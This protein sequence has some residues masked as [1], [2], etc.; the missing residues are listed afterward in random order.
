MLLFYGDNYSWAREK[1][2]GDHVY[3]SPG[4]DAVYCTMSQYGPGEVI[5]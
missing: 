1:T 4:Q 3:V 5:F 2:A